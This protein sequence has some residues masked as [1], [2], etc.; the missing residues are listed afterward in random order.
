[1]EARTITVLTAL[2]GQVS[3]KSVWS[4]ND[5][6]GQSIARMVIDDIVGYAKIKA[7][8]HKVSFDVS[9]SDGQHELLFTGTHD[10][11][12][13]KCYMDGKPQ[14]ALESASDRFSEVC[15]FVGYEL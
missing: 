6:A 8:Q 13:I 1:M 12:D 3:G 7:D 9:I 4:M 5:S 15:E 14:E 11:E 10:S 2:G